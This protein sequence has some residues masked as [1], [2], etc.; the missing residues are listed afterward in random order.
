MSTFVLGWAAFGAGVRF[1]QLALEMRPLFQR[2]TIIGYPI[3]MS[4][5]GAFGYYLQNKEAA[6]KALLEERKQRLLEKRARQAE[7]DAVA[8]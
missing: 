8:L 3:F 4:I 7:R 2:S 6:Q 1:W 5:S